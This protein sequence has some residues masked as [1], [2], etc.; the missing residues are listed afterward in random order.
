MR[1]R[2]LLAALALTLAWAAPAAAA[3]PPGANDWSC[4]PTAAHPYPVVLVHGTFGDMTVSWNLISPRL[5]QDGYCVFALDYGNRA[6]VP[7]EGSADSCATSS[8]ASWRQPAPAGSPW[9]EHHQRAAPVALPAG[10]G[11]APVDHLRR[12]CAALDSQRARSPRSGG[13]GLPSQLPARL[14]F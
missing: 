12:G 6:T 8:T 5:K 9:R 2:G 3:N 14:A 10:R 1:V 7:I 4:K 13:P 11:G